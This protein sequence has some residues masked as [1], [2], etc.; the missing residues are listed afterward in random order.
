MN[1]WLIYLYRNLTRNVRR[2]LLTCAAVGLPI[3]IF[4]LS[5]AVVNGVEAY[6]DNSA[7]QLRLVVQNRASIINPLPISYRA[8][9]ESLDPRRER[10]LS[11]CGLGWI[12]GKIEGSKLPLSTLAVEADMFLETYSEYEFTP[13]QIAQWHR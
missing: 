2:T 6:L 3:V 12:G 4:V 11:V 13:E 1:L 10:L 5:M 7:K 9:I 8:K